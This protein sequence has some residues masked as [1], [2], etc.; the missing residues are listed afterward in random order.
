MIRTILVDDES[1]GRLYLRQL[2]E[3][4]LPQIKIVGEAGNAAEALSLIEMEK[5]DLV[6]L[7]IEMPAMTGMEMLRQFQEIPFEVVF[8][9]AFNRYAAEAFRLGAVDYLLKPLSLSDLQQAVERATKN[10]AMKNNSRQ[11][12]QVLSKN[13]GQ[14]FTKITIPTL[15]G[16]E[17]IDF[18]DIV[19][20]QSESNYTSIRLLGGKMV[21]ATRTLGDFDEMLEAYRFFR[22]HKSYLIN[23]AHIRKYVKGE[24]GTVTMEDGTEIDVSRRR[25]E[26]FLASLKL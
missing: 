21:M 10:L 7:D 16:F 22:V 18:K 20:L 26:E 12:V 24:G 19:Y 3:K 15:N 17:F 5:P 25:K 1:K 8:V 11:L 23:M 13:Y 14:P 6:F 4:N 9:T 2:C